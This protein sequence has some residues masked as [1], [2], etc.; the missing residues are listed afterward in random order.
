M[1]KYFIAIVP[2]GNVFDEIEALKKTISNKYNTKGTL[3]SPAHITL[4]MPFEFDENKEQKLIKYLS[5]F[6]FESCFDIELRNL[7]C[8]EPRVIFINVLKSD[9][10][11]VL[12]KRLTNQLKQNLQIFNQADDMRGFH[13]HITIAYRDLK[14]PV[15]YQIWDE[16]Q[17]KSFEKTFTCQSFWLLKKEDKYWQLHH[18]F[19]FYSH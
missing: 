3:L 19:Q 13:P 10:L 8:F 5:D 12:Q 4:H 11:S 17:N 18:E 15:F 14:K 9:D 6:S 16:Y 1:A 2:T 7:D